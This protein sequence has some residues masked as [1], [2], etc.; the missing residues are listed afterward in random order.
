MA[1]EMTAEYRHQ[2]QLSIYKQNVCCTFV[3]V[4]ALV[5]PIGLIAIRQVADTFDGK[6]VCLHL[7]ANYWTRPIRRDGTLV[8]F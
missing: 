1:K 6:L 7:K 5:M 2:M 3:F 8:S 4:L